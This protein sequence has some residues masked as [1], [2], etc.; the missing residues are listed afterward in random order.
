MVEYGVVSMSSMQ[1]LMTESVA[2]SRE[3]IQP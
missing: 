2:D 1:D 3:K